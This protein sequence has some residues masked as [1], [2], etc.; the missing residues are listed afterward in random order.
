MG[1]VE[2]RDRGRAWHAVAATGIVGGVASAGWWFAHRVDAV[3]VVSHRNARYGSVAGY[4]ADIFT[5]AEGAPLRRTSRRRAVMRNG[6]LAE[7]AEVS[8]GPKNGR[9][10]RTYAGAT[11]LMVTVDGHACWTKTVRDPRQI[12]RDLGIGQPMIPGAERIIS[13]HRGG[14]GYRIETLSSVTGKSVITTWDIDDDTFLVRS[15][16][17]Q[18]QG[19]GVTR[20]TITRETVSA[21]A[22]T[23]PGPLCAI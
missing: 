19:G 11:S 22:L 14:H 18:T 12:S 6:K 16:T 8:M 21:P 13:A 17:T 9:V 4:E 23:R 3:D 1:R 15:R 7:L 20:M 10:V 5:G 2:M